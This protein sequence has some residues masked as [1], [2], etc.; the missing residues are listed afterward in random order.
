MGI[1]RIDLG[2]KA[3]LDRTSAPG[4]PVMMTLL[5]QFLSHKHAVLLVRA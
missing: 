2:A 5:M 3:K 4:F 1:A